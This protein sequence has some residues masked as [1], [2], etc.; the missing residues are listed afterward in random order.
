MPGTDTPIGTIVWDC[1]I[2]EKLSDGGM[3]VVYKAEDMKL[4]RFV[5]LNVL[6]KQNRR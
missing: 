5:A 2:I 3:G 4:G 6:P 1:R